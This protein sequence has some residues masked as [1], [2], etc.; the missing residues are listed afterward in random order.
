[1][2]LIKANADVG[3]TH[4]DNFTPFVLEAMRPD[5]DRWFEP[6]EV[7]HEV[8]D[9]TG[10]VLPTRVTEAV[11][12]R[13]ARKQEVVRDQGQ[14]RLAEGTADKASAGVACSWWRGCGLVSVCGPGWLRP[15]R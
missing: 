4:L 9:I 5:P 11:L 12:K 6:H 14:Y 3:R 7:A 15:W 10:L 13:S 1:M 2:A 8:S